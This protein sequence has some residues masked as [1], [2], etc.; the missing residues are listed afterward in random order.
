M[1]TLQALVIGR[2]G[3]FARLGKS[4]ITPTG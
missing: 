4:G 1:D 3:N 2:I